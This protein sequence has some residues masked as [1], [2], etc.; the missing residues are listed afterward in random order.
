MQIILKKITSSKHAGNSH[1]MNFRHVFA[2]HKKQTHF[3]FKGIMSLFLYIK[4]NRDGQAR[5]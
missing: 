1:H 4:G 2:L 3:I 5:L